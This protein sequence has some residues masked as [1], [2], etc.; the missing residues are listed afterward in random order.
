MTEV[1][2]RLRAGSGQEGEDADTAC[3]RLRW[4]SK[5]NKSSAR[6]RQDDDSTA[7][8]IPALSITSAFLCFSGTQCRKWQLNTPTPLPLPPP[9]NY[10]LSDPEA[11]TAPPPSSHKRLPPSPICAGH[12]GGI[13]QIILLTSLPTSQVQ[14]D[15]TDAFNFS[16]H[17][18]N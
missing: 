16:K 5:I 3:L 17:N 14:W 12:G 4:N 13:L 6:R 9:L 7:Y 11:P 15:P 8:C 2:F 18:R 1:G 10:F